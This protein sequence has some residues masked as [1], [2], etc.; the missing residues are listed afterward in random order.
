[1]DRRKPT[2]GGITT[3]AEA[4]QY[5]QKM[6]SLV[7][8][9]AELKE[10]PLQLAIWYDTDHPKDL[11]L[12]EIL[13]GFP[14]HEDEKEPFTTRFNSTSEFLI[15]NNGELVLT[16]L[17]PE[18]TEREIEQVSALV[19]RIREAFKRKTARVMFQP[20]TTA[21]KRILRKLKNG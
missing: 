2:G 16:L 4:L 7:R 21:T 6:K 1:M 15:A 5:P 8:S 17:G 11:F 9:H 20:S 10:N 13:G 12:M 18:E 3:V 19:K 14:S